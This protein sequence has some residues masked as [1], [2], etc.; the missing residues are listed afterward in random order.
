MIQRGGDLASQRRRHHQQGDPAV[1]R[2]RFVPG[3]QQE[4]VLLPGGRARDLRHHA[5]EPA[6]GRPHRAVVAVI[7]HPRSDPAQLG[8]VAVQVRREVAHGYDVRRARAAVV[9][10][11]IV[12]QRVGIRTVEAVAGEALEVGLP[13]DPGLGQLGADAGGGQPVIAVVADAPGRPRCHRQVIRQARIAEVAI[14][15]G[16][17]V[18]ARQAADVRLG[19]RLPGRGVLQH[20]DED[21]AGRR[22]G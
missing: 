20:D 3:N 7:A 13:R 14:I 21:V 9:R 17:G 19:Q 1:P 16:H 15:R 5:G 12:L 11:R 6:I 8:R 2:A 10:K 18:L 4:A 22:A